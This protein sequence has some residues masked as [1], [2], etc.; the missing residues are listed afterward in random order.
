MSEARLCHSVWMESSPLDV[1]IG[2][3]GVVAYLDALGVDVGVEF[4]GDD[5]QTRS[6]VVVAAISSTMAEAAG[7]RPAAPVLCDVDDVVLYLVTNFD[8]PDGSWHTTRSAYGCSASSSAWHFA[9]RTRLP[10][11][12]RRRAVIVGRSVAGY[13]SCPIISHAS[14]R[15]C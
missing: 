1:E 13:R 12:R 9:E 3:F 15:C 7:Q 5:S 10:W 6:L 8:V 4:G 14:D 2:S 11:S